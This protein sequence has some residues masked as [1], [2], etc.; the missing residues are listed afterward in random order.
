MPGRRHDAGRQPGGGDQ[1]PVEVTLTPEQVRRFKIIQVLGPIVVKGIMEDGSEHLIFGRQNAILTE[2]IETEGERT[3]LVGPPEAVAAAAPE[4]E[5]A[6]PVERAREAVVHVAGAAADVAGNVLQAARDRVAGHDENGGDANG[7]PEAGAGNGEA[8]P[9]EPTPE[10]APQQPEPE[11]EPAPEQP[12]PMEVA[13]QIIDTLPEGQ[14]REALEALA[15][16]FQTEFERL[17]ARVTELE[18]QNTQL[19]ERAGRMDAVLQRIQ[20]G[21]QVTPEEAAAARAP[22]PEPTPAPGEAAPVPNE[23]QRVQQIENDFQVS[24]QVRVRGEDQPRTIAALGEENDQLV[25]VLHRDGTDDITVP[26][27]QLAEWQLQAGTMTGET[28]PP[29]ATPE[30]TPPAPAATAA[31]TAEAAP[32]PVD[33][34]PADEEQQGRRRRLGRAGAVLGGAALLGLGVGIGWYVWG[35]HGAPSPKDLGYKWVP[36]KGAIGKDQVLH[37]YSGHKNNGTTNAFGVQAPRGFDWVKHVTEKGKIFY[38]LLNEKKQTVLDHVKFKGNGPV[39]DEQVFSVRQ[40][41]HE[42][43]V[44]AGS[45]TWH[46]KDGLSHAFRM[47][48]IFKK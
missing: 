6:G 11:P 21:E 27:R 38:S 14:V 8:A 12:Q 7:A 23:G 31:A 36:P 4:A 20:N 29:P 16:Q 47:T 44:K 40:R 46:D 24:Q 19:Q 45:L 34:V 43:G 42:L 41:F 3:Y 39:I 17:N 26:R 5:Q 10:P 18:Q 25:A 35:R 22:A 30:P 32:G 9:A 13:R 33:N 48:S 1:P 15:A 28:P 37:W 2:H